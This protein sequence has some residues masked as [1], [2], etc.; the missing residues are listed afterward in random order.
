MVVKDKLAVG[1][2][3]IFMSFGLLNELSTIVQDATQIAALDLDPE[4]RTK[5]LN[6]IF[7]ERTKS[8]RKTKDVEMDD[9]EISYQDVET[10]LDWAKDHLM[11]FFI[12]RLESTA[13]VVEQTKT[14]MEKVESSLLGSNEG[15]SAT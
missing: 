5:T 9:L 15:V 1:D 3:E 13:K 14:R 12:R 4:I 8:G 2:R 10:A 11:G 7:A 6:A